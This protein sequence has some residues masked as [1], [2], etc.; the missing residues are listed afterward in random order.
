[1]RLACSIGYVVF[2][3]RMLIEQVS[4]KVPQSYSKNRITLERGVEREGEAAN[5]NSRESLD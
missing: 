2:H 3:A 5:A 4:Q 1:M